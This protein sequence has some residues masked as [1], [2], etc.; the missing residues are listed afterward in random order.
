MEGY[1]S[2]QVLLTARFVAPQD[3]AYEVNPAF[4][5]LSCWCVAKQVNVAGRFQSELNVEQQTLATFIPAAE[6]HLLV[7][8]F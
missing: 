4:R 7:A 3:F 6:T 8:D 1:R 2:R 5:R